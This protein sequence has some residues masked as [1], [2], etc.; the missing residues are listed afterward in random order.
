M[1]ACKTTQMSTTPLTDVSITISISTCTL[2]HFLLFRISHHYTICSK[3]STDGS[4]L[5]HLL[6]SQCASVIVLIALWWTWWFRIPML[7]SLGWL[8][9]RALSAQSLKSKFTGKNR[10]D[11][12]KELTME[13]DTSSTS[14]HSS[15]ASIRWAFIIRL[16][17]K[18]RSIRFSRGILFLWERSNWR[19]CWSLLDRMASGV[20]MIINI[21][22][23]SLVPA[24]FAAAND[25]SQRVFTRRARSGKKLITCTLAQSAS[26]NKLKRASDSVSHRLYWTI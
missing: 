15:S 26:S 8:R 21:W 17:F 10:S 25:T 18:Q 24:S 2:W 16:I 20:S 4:I 14:S 13:P 6:S 3:R 11:H 23:S 19:T 5:F 9:R 12:T 7:S 1:N 22:L